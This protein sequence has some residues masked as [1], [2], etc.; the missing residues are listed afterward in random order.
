MRKKDGPYT[1]DAERGV[2]VRTHPWLCS[3]SLSVLSQTIRKWLGFTLVQEGDSSQMCV[4]LHCIEAKLHN[5]HESVEAGRHQ[6]K[7]ER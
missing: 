3:D 5:K 7:D 4:R 1:L 2:Y 6:T